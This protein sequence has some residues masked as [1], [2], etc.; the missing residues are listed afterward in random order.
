MTDHVLL[1]PPVTEYYGGFEHAEGELEH[2]GD[3]LGVDVVVYRLV[4]GWV[5][6]YENDGARN[7]DWYGWTVPLLAPMAATI[8]M[9]RFNPE[10]NSP[11]TMGNPPAS[12]IHFL[13]DDGVRVTYGHVQ[14]VLVAE[15]DRVQPGDVVALI[16][17]N[18]M[19]RNP[20][21]H[22]GAWRDDTPLQIR[23]DLAIL[24]A[25]RRARDADRS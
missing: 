1:H 16:G 14:D 21:T 17:N 11:G 7:E 23:F 5:R 6:A 15:G 22:V 8:E 25:L 9:V 20:H 19:C 12:A 24:G 3:A 18:G 4:D 2:I 13:S 10:T